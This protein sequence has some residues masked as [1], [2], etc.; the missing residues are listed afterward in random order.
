MAGFGGPFG[1]PYS[2]PMGWGGPW[3][4]G[5]G[6]PSFVPDSGGYPA[7]GG[8]GRG[9]GRGRGIETGVSAGRTLVNDVKAMLGGASPGQTLEVCRFAAATLARSNPTLYKQFLA[10]LRVETPSGTQADPRGSDATRQAVI[11]DRQA[12]W[13]EL[14]AADTEV[15]YFNETVRSLKLVHGAQAAV[16][17][18]V[19]EDESVDL[20]RFL[21]GRARKEELLATAG[22]VRLGTGL[23]LSQPVEVHSDVGSETPADAADAARRQQH[24]DVLLQ[25]ARQNELLAQIILR[26]P[27]GPHEGGLG[28]PQGTVRPP[29]VWP[30]P[31]VRPAGVPAPAAVRPPEQ[32]AD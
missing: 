21:R 30:Q 12:R 27:Q 23:D 25:I 11:A 18:L 20:R 26:G 16:D 15:T 29:V 31:A 10:G 7:R 4:Q 22:L 5:W 3:P 6:G 8:R 17:D 19:R 1:Q 9:R 28:A 32:K 2:T 14:C 13:R 24:E